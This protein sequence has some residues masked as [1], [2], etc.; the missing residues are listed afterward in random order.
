MACQT[1]CLLY[2]TG[3]FWASEVQAKIIGRKVALTGKGRAYGGTLVV[4]EHGHG[5]GSRQVACG[6]L[7][8]T[9]HIDYGRVF[10]QV[11]IGLGGEGV[12]AGFA[13]IMVEMSLGAKIEVLFSAGPSGCTLA[14]QG[15]LGKA[16]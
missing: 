5:V 8:R 14:N 16:P 13:K 7:G 10:C 15:M 1:G 12:H 11:Q 6:K 9:A 2:E 4:A 3:H